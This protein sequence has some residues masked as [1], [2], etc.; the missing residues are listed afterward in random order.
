M[1]P[2]VAADALERQAVHVLPIGG[3]QP[4]GHVAPGVVERARDGPRTSGGVELE[5]G[6]R[7]RERAFARVH[8]HRRRVI[9]GDQPRLIQEQR[10]LELVGDAQLVAAVPRRAG[11]SRR[12][13]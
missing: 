3:E 5:A 9:D 8:L 7:R 13:A 10:L 6:E 2:R 11:A 4:R 1:R 12:S